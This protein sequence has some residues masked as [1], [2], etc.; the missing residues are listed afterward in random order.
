[1]KNLTRY[2]DWALVTGASS[3]IGREFARCL[4]RDGVNCFLVARRSERL[5]DLSRELSEN[6]RVECRC[7]VQDLTEDG[8]EQRIKEAV[9]DTHVSILVNNAGFGHPGHFES[10]DPARLTELVKLNCLLPVLLTR[11]FLPEMIESGRGAIVFVS[12][13]LGFIPAPYDSVYCASKA[14]DLYLGESLWGELRGTGV[15]VITVCPN[16]TKTEFFAVEGHS[17]SRRK[18]V[19]KFADKAESI[20]AMTLKKLGRTPTTAPWSAWGPS[21]LVR[22]LPRR[23]VAGIMRFVMTHLMASQKIE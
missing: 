5:E 3:G 23:I 1:M 10:R 19:M 13:V 2:G 17:E 20:A 4:A 22:M 8:A 7:I 14:F 11:L 16:A 21:I 15:D 18:I 9:G 12:S 6:H